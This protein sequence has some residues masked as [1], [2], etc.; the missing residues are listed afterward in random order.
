MMYEPQKSDLCIVAQKLSNKP[1]QLGAEAVERR[2]GAEGNTVEPSM[3]RTLCR[4]SMSQG[5]DRVRAVAKATKRNAGRTL[6]RHSPKVGARCVNCARRDLCGGH[7]VTDVPTAM[8]KKPSMR[9][10]RS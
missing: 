2:Q 6:H 7:R 3:F 8:I 1:G 9:N 4:V 5:L 10:R